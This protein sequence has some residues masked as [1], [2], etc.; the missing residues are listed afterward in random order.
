MLLVNKIH[1][2]R[3]NKEILKNISFSL[4]PR[5]IIHLVGKN[6]SGKTTLLKII[7]NILDANE[8]EI[9]WN[10]K[11][12]KKN[13]YEFYKDVTFIMDNQSSNNSLTVN[14]NI[15]FWHKIFSSKIKHK[16]IKSILELLS[17]D[18]YKNTKIN[19]LSFGE[20]KKLELLRLIIEQ[21]KLWVLDEPFIGLDKDSVEL[22]SQTFS[23][24][25]N[26]DGMVIFTS[27]SLH[28]IKNLDIFNMETY[29]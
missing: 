1:F 7:C 15:L 13:P 18:Q 27:H 4:S 9:I 29:A 16:E 10:G 5:K 17:L 28:E 8:G 21:K 20:V 23:N 26:L 25:T 22:I 6:G 2:K 24:H 11:N 14:E 12:I 3:N 19:E